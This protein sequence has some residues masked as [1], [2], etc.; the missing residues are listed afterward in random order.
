MAKQA[1]LQRIQTEEINATQSLNLVKN[2]LRSGL[3]CIAFMRGM[4]SSECF[5]KQ[6]ISGITVHTLQPTEPEPRKMMDWIDQGCLPSV[7]RRYLEEL[8][9]A[10]YG[11]FKS[12]GKDMFCLIETYNFRVRYHENDVVLTR[13]AEGKQVTRTVPTKSEI[14]QATVAMIRS[15]ISMGGTMP[16]LPEDRAF[17]M[18]LLYREDVTPE[19]YEPL[20]FRPASDDNELRFFSKPEVVAIGSIAT[21]YHELT[22]HSLVPAEDEIEIAAKYS[23]CTSNDERI[24]KVHPAYGANIGVGESVT[25]CNYIE[26]ETKCQT[27]DQLC[28]DSDRSLDNQPVKDKKKAQSRLPADETTDTAHN[29]QTSQ[30]MSFMEIQELL[31]A[32]KN[33]VFQYTPQE[34]RLTWPRAADRLNKLIAL[35]KSPD[36][37][38]QKALRLQFEICLILHGSAPHRFFNAFFRESGLSYQEI[39]RQIQALVEDGIAIKNNKGQT[40]LNKAYS[41]SNIGGTTHVDDDAETL[42]TAI[43]SGRKQSAASILKSET[44]AR[45]LRFLSTKIKNH[46]ENGLISCSQSEAGMSQSSAIVKGLKRKIS[47][48]DAIHQ[49]SQKKMKKR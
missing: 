4:F 39:R 22:L 20:H 37:D 49:I 5:K 43:T 18:K 38:N 2:L 6:K 11:K 9:F 28:H 46:I 44:N 35:H 42:E 16:P 25:L 15:L 33:G 17:S 29:E 27:E 31:A 19:D 21:P 40:L 8:V 1:Q 34:I 7:E 30:V 47:T 26:P 24:P 14:S 12:G 45:S 23:Q 3:S 10:I 32:V 13:K 48:S 36:F 41:E